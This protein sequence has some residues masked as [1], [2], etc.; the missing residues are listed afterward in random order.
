MLIACSIALLVIYAGTKLLIQSKK[1]ALGK[2]YLGIS[3]FLII[4]G[5]FVVMGSAC[6]A[7]M[8]HCGGNRGMMEKKCIIMEERSSGVGMMEH[9]KM[10]GHPMSMK[11][12]SG[13]MEED[14]NMQMMQGSCGMGSMSGRCMHHGQDCESACGSDCKHRS[15][16]KHRGMGEQGENC[17]MKDGMKKDAACCKK[18]SLSKKGK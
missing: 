15:G 1:E 18:D 7:C 4:A 5:L 10:M 12:C 6:F 17:M 2:L 11:G 9:R 16:C 8:S 3:W 14:C 13:M